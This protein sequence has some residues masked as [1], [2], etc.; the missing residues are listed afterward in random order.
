MF[1]FLSRHAA[2][3]TRVLLVES[4]SRAIAEKVL[5]LLYERHS[6]ETVDL[7]T[8]FEGQPVAF[9][10]AGGRVLRSFDYPDRHARRRLMR[11]LR[12]RQYSV[13][14]IVCSGEPYLARYKF[15]L[16]MLLAAKVLIVNEHADYFWCDR[17]SLGTLWRL[18]TTRAGI[19]SEGGNRTLFRIAAFPFQL[20]LLMGFAARVHLMR[21]LRLLFRSRPA[22]TGNRFHRPAQ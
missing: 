21:G 14:A 15:A 13:L 17:G 19:G 7:L 8:C 6:A 18:F 4:G 12:S 5:P 22:G 1:R 11:D 9:H 16:A 20:L 10:A 3:F 2:P